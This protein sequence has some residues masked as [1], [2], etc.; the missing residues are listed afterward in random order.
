MP[1]C[2]NCGNE[3]A[4][5][6]CPQCG[7]RA[8]NRLAISAFVRDV[9][10]DQ[11]SVDAKIPR[12][13]GPLFLKPG[14]LTAEFIEGRGARYI[15]PFR[16]YLLTS[17]LFFLLLSFLSGRSDWAER[18][19]KEIKEQSDSVAAHTGAADT[20]TRAPDAV[21]GVR[22]GVSRNG[23]SWLEKTEVNVPWKWLDQKIEANLAALGKLPPAVAMRRVTD[24]TIEELPKVMFI[25]LPVYALL[26]KLLYARRKRYY[27]EHFIFAL[28]VH[29]FTFLLF[30]IALVTGFDWAILILS[31][32]LPVYT[33]AAMKR[34][35]Q[36]G[37]FKTFLKWG[38]LGFVYS[39]LL[40]FGLMFAFIWALAGAP[41]S[42]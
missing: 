34:V 19:E 12:T 38:T 16:L 24:A 37:Y 41:S 42:A 14:F 17:L 29:A 23:E 21:T 28:H 39:T 3:R 31:I 40:L 8:G 32:I 4:E 36:Q 30:T 5:N 13:L 35:Y 1:T 2:L 18:A 10:D 22:I 15:P 33:F 20:V 25:M 7:Q 6:F 9:V 26:L 11:L 27:I